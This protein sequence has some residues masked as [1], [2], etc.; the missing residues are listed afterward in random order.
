[1]A[2]EGRLVGV[3]GRAGVERVLGGGPSGA[4][5]GREGEDA[6]RPGDLVLPWTYFSLAPVPSG[7]PGTELE[8]V[9]AEGVALMDEPFCPSLAREIVRE[10][11]ALEA[12]RFR[13]LPDQDARGVVQRWPPCA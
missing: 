2:E 11:G 9:L 6:V 7:L 13:R 5:D 12:A 4:C 10:V 3:L 1:G 8:N